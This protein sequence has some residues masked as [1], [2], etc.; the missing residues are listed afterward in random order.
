MR[1]CY[2]LGDW[3][4]GP[5]PGRPSTA[6]LE[7]LVTTGGAAAQTPFLFIPIGCDFARP[8]PDLLDVVAAWNADAY[9][10]TGVWAVAATFD[11]Y[12]QLLQA[13]R[14]AL[15]ARRFDP[16]PYWTGFYA[17]QALLAAETFGAIADATARHDPIAWRAQ[18]SAR[19]AE[20]HSGWTT[21]VPGNHHDFITGTALDPV[22]ETE[23]LPRLTAALTQGETARTRASAEIAAA[24]RP[25][26]SDAATTVVAF[27]PLG[28]PRRGL[29][30]VPGPDTT[31]ASRRSDD[32]ASAEGGRLFLAHLPSLGYAT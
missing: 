13:H 16:T 30:E 21:L 3:T 17:T 19:T 7:K 9:A 24:I 28:F 4:L 26:P 29:V 14:K 11:H 27:N 2:C 25:R 10:R 31:T 20:I 1:V 23:Q 15:P 18:V 6:A 12:A 22:Y 32:Q 8:R 5:V